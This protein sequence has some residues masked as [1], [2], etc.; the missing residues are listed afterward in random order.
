M[1]I[2]QGS[3]FTNNV[4]FT[5]TRENP[6]NNHTFALFDPQKNCGNLMTPVTPK[7]LTGAKT[8]RFGDGDRPK[9]EVPH[10][11]TEVVVF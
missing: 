3:L 2:T 10:P 11:S 4:L 6:Q 5:M 8:L 9:R 7:L 1:P